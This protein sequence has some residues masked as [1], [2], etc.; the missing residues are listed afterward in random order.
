M[1]TFAQASDGSC[2]CLPLY[3]LGTACDDPSQCQSGDCG[4]PG[5]GACPPA[6]VCIG[7]QCIPIPVTSSLGNAS[8]AALIQTY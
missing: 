7:T 5:S 3:S 6:D 4:V 8:C 1:G 2:L